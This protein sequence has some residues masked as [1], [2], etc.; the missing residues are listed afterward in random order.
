MSRTETFNYEVL[1]K[2]G[3]EIHKLITSLLF[4]YCKYVYFQSKVCNNKACDQHIVCLYQSTSSKDFLFQCCFWAI[5]RRFAMLS[6]EQMCAKLSRSMS[7]KHVPFSGYAELDGFVHTHWAPPT[8]LHCQ[9][10]VVTESSLSYG[11]SVYPR[12][13]LMTP[14]L[15][16]AAPLCHF[17]SYTIIKAE[18]WALAMPNGPEDAYTATAPYCSASEAESDYR[19]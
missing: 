18:T 7:I 5:I 19:W 11:D 9:D 14:S 15:L 12:S 4:N 6:L 10:N 1:K 17:P 16:L 13:V 2:Q 8:P 3:V